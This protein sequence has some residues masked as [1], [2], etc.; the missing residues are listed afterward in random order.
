[1]RRGRGREPSVVLFGAGMISRAHGAAAGFSNMPIVAVASRSTA[2]AAERAAEFDARPVGYDDIVQRRVEADIAVVCT[3][4]QCHARDAIALLDAGYGVLLEKPLCRTLAEADD[5]VE[6]SARHGGRLLYAENLAYAPVVQRL[7][8]LVPQLGRPN[9][10][11]VRSLQALPEWGGFTTDEW[12][13]GALFDLGVHPLSVA[14]LVA[15]AAGEGTPTSVRAALRGSTSHG[16]DEHAELFVT[17]ASGLDVRIESSWQHGPAP[18]WDAQ[19]SSPTGVLRAE[20]LPDPQ[21]EHNGDPVPLPPVTMRVAQIEQYGYLAQMRAL[22][23][24]LQHGTTPLM[25]ASFGRLVLDVVCAAYCSAGRGGAPQ[26]LPFAG[27]RDRTPLQ[28][29][30]GA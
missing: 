4:P 25:S 1:M 16:S 23:S 21:L 8:A 11:E 9:H 5:I 12:G 10:I 29:W 13:G 2:R 28:L 30:R 18:L 22:A 3:P 15:N 27:A 24:D 7:L 20:L 26:A 17:Y 19:V 6:A 14:L